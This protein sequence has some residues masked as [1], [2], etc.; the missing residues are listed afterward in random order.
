M[1]THVELSNGIKMPVMGLGTWLSK[2][3]EVEDAVRNAIDV[4]YRLI[5]TAAV[6]GNE[7]EIGKVLKEY[8]EE[9]KLKR[10]DIFITTKLWCTHLHPNEIEAEL[11]DSLKKLQLDYVDLYLVHM[12]TAFSSDMSAQDHS[13]K[14][15]DTWKGMEEAYKKGLARSIGV[16]NFSADQIHRIQ[17]IASVP[18]HN[19]QVELHLYFPQFELQEVCNQYKI[20]L[21]AYAPLGSPGRVNFNL[22]NWEKTP[23]P[24][25]NDVVL[26][27]AKKYHKT[28]A[29]I[30]LRHLIQRKIAVI[31]KSVNASR[32]KE[33]FEVFDFSLTVEE[34]NE[35]NN[36]PRGKR[37]FKQEFLV[38]HPEDPMKDE[39]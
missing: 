8:F 15:E 14:V 29:Q 1:S 10:E 28:P 23:N 4:G 31:P 9:G 32:I 12:P 37:I 2:P 25:E 13:V 38:G 5:D 20:S 18:I 7:A 36:V 21:T 17:K 16:S 11:R 6:Y 26:K 35:L 30:L 22:V 34:I 3:E 19:N 27:L 24:L 33:N 39:R